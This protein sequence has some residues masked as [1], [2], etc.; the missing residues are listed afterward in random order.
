MAHL[1]PQWQA[2]LPNVACSGNF[3]RTVAFEHELAQNIQN[4]YEAVEHPLTNLWQVSEVFRRPN[5]VAGSSEFIEESRAIRGKEQT[6][7]VEAL[8]TLAQFEIAQA[9]MLYK[10][11][12][13]TAEKL[14]K[15]H[16]RAFALAEGC[17]LDVYGHLHP[18]I[19]GR[20]ISNGTFAEG[21]R[22]AVA[23]A[24][25]VKADPAD[26][27]DRLDL[28]HLFRS[29]TQVDD[30][31]RFLD[32]NVDQKKWT[33]FVANMVAIVTRLENIQ[34]EGFKTTVRPIKMTGGLLNRD[35][36]VVGKVEFLESIR[37]CRDALPGFSFLTQ[38]HRDMCENF[39]KEAQLVFEIAYAKSRFKTFQ[40]AD[41]DDAS[42]ARA[43]L[44]KQ[45]RIAVA[46]C[47]RLGGSEADVQRLNAEVINGETDKTT[48]RERKGYESLT[49]YASWSYRAVTY[50]PN[51]LLDPLV[52]L[53]KM[54]KHLERAIAEEQKRIN[55]TPVGAAPAAP[56]SPSPAGK[57][58]EKE[59]V[60]YGGP[61]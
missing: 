39:F 42:N 49:Q 27:S 19:G 28:S 38:A 29:S 32:L 47:R 36:I 35:E 41:E 9:A 50:V 46:A 54:G 43:Q 52:S 51:S 16:V 37:E 33:G 6:T 11:V 13:P 59:D 60:G 40:A 57:K 3:C 18:V 45:V 12:G 55:R 22:E 24:K 2:F 15:E 10:V 8:E 48:I 61:R 20:I 4:W 58:A 34:A 23:K 44:D 25:P 5:T 14:G 7:L 21:T 1:A 56:A 53:D 17:T 30:F 31:S 26:R